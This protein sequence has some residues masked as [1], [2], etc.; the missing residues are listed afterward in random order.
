MSEEI[1]SVELLQKD[2]WRMLKTYRKS[3]S[4]QIDSFRHMDE[5][6]EGMRRN[7]IGYD[8]SFKKFGLDF[9][10]VITRCPE[11]LSNWAESAVI[12][13]HQVHI[14]TG[15]L[16]TDEFYKELEDHGF[17]KGTHFTHLFS[18]SQHGIDTG[19]TVKYDDRG[20]PLMDKKDWDRAK[21]DYAAKIG[22]DALWDDSPVYGRYFPSTSNY[23]TFA[24]ENFHEEVRWMIEGRDSVG[25]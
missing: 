14:M 2:F 22:I 21:G 11:L 3:R 24:P 13:G 23:I 4:D 6:L 8:S 9:H 17:E 5:V 10:G 19:K 12:A 7:V 18:I 15:S 1:N 16:K 20:R 25:R